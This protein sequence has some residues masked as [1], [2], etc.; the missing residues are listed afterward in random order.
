[1]RRRTA[2]PVWEVDVPGETDRTVPARKPLKRPVLARV[3]EALLNTF[4]R[5]DGQVVRGPADA[6]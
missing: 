3:S 2:P 1:M 6:R 5:R 4:G